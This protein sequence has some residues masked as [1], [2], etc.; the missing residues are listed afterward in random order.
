MNT[1]FIGGSRRV[2]RLNPTIRERLDNIITKGLRIVIG[3][4][5]GSDRAV[6][7]YLAERGHRNVVVY[8]MANGCRNNLGDWPVRAVEAAGERGFEYYA[9]KD[10]EMAKAGDCGFMIWDGRSKGTLL[11]I[12]RLLSDAK[13]VVVYF[14]PERKCHTLRAQRELDKLLVKAPREGRGHVARVAQGTQAQLFSPKH[15]RGPG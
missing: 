11:N 6:Q 15:G 9:L 10:A 8:C 13:P 14:A 12:Q 2:A 7:G 4:A 1:V 5:N 3:D